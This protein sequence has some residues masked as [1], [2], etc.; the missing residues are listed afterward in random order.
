MG[1]QGGYVL[2]GDLKSAGLFPSSDS[3]DYWWIP[4]RRIFFSSSAKDTPADELANATAHFFLPRRFQDPF[5]NNATVLYDANDLLILETVDPLQNRFTT[6]E[7]DSN[8]NITNRNDYRVMQPT[9]VTDP[10][11][12]RAT[13]AF[14]TLG[15][16]A[17]TAA[18]GKLSENLGDSLTGF[19][20]DLRQADIDQFFGNPKGRVAA[21]LL[22]N[23]SSRIIYDLDRFQQTNAANPHDPAQSVPAFAAT[24]ARETHVSDLGGNQLTKLQIGFSYSDGFGREIQKKIQADPGPI[25]PNGVTVN[26][27]WVASG[28]TIFN[29]KAKPVR[30]YE[31][32]FDDTHDFKYGV[33]V[34]VSPILFYDP[35]GRIVATLHPNETWE[36]VVFNPWRQESWDAN[37]TVLIADPSLDADVGAFFQRVPSADYLPTWYGQRSGGQLGV[38]ERDSATKAAAHAATPTVAWLD[39]LGRTFLTVADNAAGGKYTTRVEFDIEGKQRCVTDALGRK[40][41][42]YD[43]DMVGTKFHQN[44]ADAGERWTLNDTRGKPLFGWNSRGFQTR[45]EF[46]RLR[47]P[48]KLFVRLNADPELLAEKIVYGEGQPNDQAA[49]LRGNVFQSFDGAG[50]VA[51]SAYDFKGNLI[52]SSRQFLTEY[53]NQVDWSQAQGP[54]ME[55]ET[56]ASATTFDALNRPVALTTPDTGV[57]RP[58]YS[59]ANL[60]QQLNVNLRGAANT[61]PFVLSIYYNVRRQRELIECGN[62]ANTAYDYDPRTFRLTHLKTMRKS[63]NAALQDLTYSYDPVGNITQIQDAAQQTVYFNNQ[64]VMSTNDYTYDAIYRLIKAKGREHIG[65]VA[66]RQPEYDWN[67]SPRVNLPHPND[68]NA[69][70]QYAELYEYDAVGNFLK[71]IHQA[72]NGTWTRRYSYLTE[73]SNSLLAP[74]KRLF[75][76]SLAGDPTDGPFSAKYTYDLNGNILQMPNLPEMEWDFKDLLHATRQQVVINPRGEKTYYA[77]DAEG[78][79]VRKVT[80]TPSGIKKHERFYLNGF[81]VYRE[82][83]NSGST[84]LER[85]TLHVMDDKQRIAMVENLTQ[86]ND[87]SPPQLIRYQFSN[88]LGSASLE[89]EGAARIISYEEYYPYGSTSYQVVDR[90]TKARAKRYRYTGKERDEET[91]FTYHGARYYAPWLGRWT[92]CD[93]AGIADGPNLYRYARNA[94]ISYTDSS[95]RDPDP[96]EAQRQKDDEQLQAIGIT[97]QQLVDY[98]SMPWGDFLGKYGGGSLAGEARLWWNFPKTKVHALPGELLYRVLPKNDQTTYMFPSGRVGTIASETATK[99]QNFD[100][101]T[102]LGG[103]A[104]VA[105]RGVEAVRGASREDTERAAGIAGAFGNLANAGLAAPGS[106]SRGIVPASTSSEIGSAKNALANSNAGAGVPTNQRGYNSVNSE[107]PVSGEISD[108]NCIPCT[109]AAMKNIIERNQTATAKNIDPVGLMEHVGRAGQALKFVANATGLQYDEKPIDMIQ[110]KEVSAAE[111]GHYALI[112]R[113]KAG[114]HMVYAQKTSLGFVIYDAQHAKVYT[115]EEFR[116]QYS[117]IAGY[118][119]H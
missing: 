18:M 41:M 29:N 43:Y 64:V 53:K 105:T 89:L 85:Q 83:D 104:S 46:D 38:P 17:G 99:L 22:G 11:G 15:L 107:D 98:V 47:R 84:T 54:A 66:D 37:D 28:W 40:I 75:S 57:I 10:N 74:N 50:V 101:G 14:D 102:P 35:V 94:P 69:M 112:A 32:F 3:N 19:Q 44:S 20:A 92:S 60:L 42:T 100:P 70:R 61:T 91:G 25:V 117:S 111:S 9:L 106:A 118:H 97:R 77:Y 72:V 45:H 113:T 48:T 119:F 115:L 109:A 5:G 90:T 6:G 71:M 93:P 49:N 1:E 103:V 4:S 65:Q 51:H 87:G 76:T 73:F 79:R 68:G 81:E 8:N 21:I 96:S 52:K 23:A 27:R 16:V 80:E 67:D 30:Q 34:G 55:K 13:V 108:S 26:P 2:S 78:Q 82:F 86:G 116:K 39:T 36:K 33:T 56:N 12:N 95:G 24:I 59:E 7:R 88:H 63:D 58:I 110:D 62:G 114:G 31:P